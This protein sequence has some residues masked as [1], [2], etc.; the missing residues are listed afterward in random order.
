M[1]TSIRAYLTREPLFSWVETYLLAYGVEITQ[2]EERTATKVYWVR[3]GRR[4]AS[5]SVAREFNLPSDGDRYLDHRYEG[6]QIVHSVLRMLEKQ[7][8]T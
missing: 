7:P 8:N 6:Q 4:Q 3:R 1:P 5:F 2:M